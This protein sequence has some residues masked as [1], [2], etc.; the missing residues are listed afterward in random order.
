MNQSE[1]EG[2][3]PNL[4]QARENACEQVAIGFGLSFTSDWFIKKVCRAIRAKH[5]VTKKVHHV[6]QAEVSRDASIV[7]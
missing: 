5:H 7:L 4:R 3:T 2:S 1:L 6:V